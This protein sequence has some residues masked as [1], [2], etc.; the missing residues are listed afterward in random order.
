MTTAAALYQA[1][2]GYL[3][4]GYRAIYSADIHIPL[5]E[6]PVVCKEAVG[7][8]CRAGESLGVSALALSPARLAC[9]CGGHGPTS[10]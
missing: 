8:R 4:D 3:H 5:M 1:C 2:G 9:C 6:S 10:G 7:A